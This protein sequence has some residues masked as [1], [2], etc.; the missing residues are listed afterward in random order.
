MAGGDK[1]RTGVCYPEEFLVS[2]DL[3]RP[4]RVA[5]R[6]NGPSTAFGL[7]WMV[8]CEKTG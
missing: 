4:S 2:I 3:V 8:L 7:F 5:G 1:S 6:N